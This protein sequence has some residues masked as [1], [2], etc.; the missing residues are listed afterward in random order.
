MK[1]Q[2]QIALMSANKDAKEAASASSGE[3]AKQEGMM[4]KLQAFITV[5]YYKYMHHTHTHT[6]TLKHTHTHT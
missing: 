6:H 2:K 4:A 1:Q 3:P 5:V